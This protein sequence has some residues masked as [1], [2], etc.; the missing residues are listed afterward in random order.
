MGKPGAGIG[1][2]PAARRCRFCSI[3][4]LAASQQP[5]AESQQRFLIVNGDTL[6][7]VDVPAMLDGHRRIGR[8]GDDG[9]HP[10]S[11]AGQIWRRDRGGRPLG[12]RIHR[13]GFRDSAI[14]SSVFKSLKLVRSRD[15]KTEFR[16]R[17]SAPSIR[18]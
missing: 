11:A 4:P 3:R 10:E 14:T 9:A 12:A 8:P 5:T 7:D 15:S 17:R 16:H 1:G 18:N 2:R 13:A 6:T